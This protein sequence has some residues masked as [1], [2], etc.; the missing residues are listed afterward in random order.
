MGGRP[1]TEAALLGHTLPCL[2][3]S[4]GKCL[5]TD[6][7]LPS[8]AQMEHG[9][10]GLRAAP[11]PDMAEAI[12]G[13]SWLETSPKPLLSFGSQERVLEQYHH[14]TPEPPLSHRVA[15]STTF[16]CLILDQRL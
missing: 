5:D 9:L 14:P 3:C 15:A 2:S 4:A 6:I 13:A 8:V 10:H 11:R 1:C 12:Q 7:M 16:L